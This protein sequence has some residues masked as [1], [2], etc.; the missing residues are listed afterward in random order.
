MNSAK[1]L[2][3]EPSPVS[4][5]HPDNYRPYIILNTTQRCNYRCRM[6]FWSK[7]EV[8]RHLEETDPTM[9]ME[10]F[11]R[12]LEEIVPYCRCLCLAGA[13]EFLADPFR[14]E[15]FSILGETLRRY[16]EVMLYQTSNASLLSADR[17]QFLKGVQKVGFTL[18]ID[19]VDALTYA[20]IRRPGIL[21]K[22]RENIRNLRGELKALGVQEVHIRLNV[23]IMKRNIFSLPDVLHFAKEI[24]A[25]VYIDHPQGFGPDD[26][27]Q[28]SLFRF[29]AFSNS[30]LGR[31]G[32]LA[33]QLNVEFQRPPDF[34]IH[35]EEVEK[36]FKA[37]GE[38]NLYCYQLNSEGPIQ[39]NANGDVS[40]CCQNLVFGNLYQQSFK[41]I[42]FS[43]RFGDYRQAIAA[44]HPLSPCDHCRHLYRM[45]PYLYESSVYD[46][47]IPPECRNLDPQPDLEKEGFFDWI[48]EL[49]E[50]QLRHQLG[51]EYL[52][53]GK[54][55]LTDGL[56][57]ELT[58]F[59]KQ[60]ARN[61]K[62][63][64]WIRG[65]AKIVVYPAG[66][67]A[68]WL[69]KNTLLS[70]VDIVGFSDRNPVL[71]GKHF[72]GY[73]VYAPADIPRLNPDILLVASELYENEICKDLAHLQVNGTKI[74]TL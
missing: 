38:K 32:E 50:K 3:E 51:E 8:A 33:K 11:R 43:P 4:I 17:L 22:V 27:D 52:A 41:E 71:H 72:H 25:A 55:L 62:F 35:P 44:G 64:S 54:R 61:E 40:V 47:N 74:L 31:C 16:P 73:K 28:E 20:S 39:I 69:L 63:A 5:S 26:L 13:G 48:D 58:I 1:I 12:A 19:S 7:P 24:H 36:Y 23:V 14:D 53:K 49:S 37:A 60:K 70:Q 30:F 66:G 46:L 15:R 18:S 29:P 34:A 68:A 56:V 65:H 67:E 42:F 45:A 59:Q 10:L 6:C 57:E 2:D 9:P 21:A